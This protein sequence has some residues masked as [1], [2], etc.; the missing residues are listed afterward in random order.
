[1]SQS[2]CLILNIF[3]YRVQTQ[4][5]LCLDKSTRPHKTKAAKGRLQLLHFNSPANTVIKLIMCFTSSAINPQN[6]VS[7]LAICPWR[8][9]TGCRKA[10]VVAVMWLAVRMYHLQ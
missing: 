4:Y 10:V 3:G 5:Y 8:V 7:Y 9:T 6:W 1:M 2:F